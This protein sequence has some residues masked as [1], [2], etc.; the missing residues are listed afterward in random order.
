[1]TFTQMKDKTHCSQDADKENCQA[2]PR[3]GLHS[4]THEQQAGA[5]VGSLCLT[6]GQGWL[7][8]VATCGAA[9]LNDFSG[10]G[11]AWGLSLV[12]CSLPWVSEG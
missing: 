9:N 6:G 1:M 2:R 4:G 8:F 12:V 11:K 3:S 10:L 5:T 7:A